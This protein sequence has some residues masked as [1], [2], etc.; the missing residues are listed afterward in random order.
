MAA[1]SNEIINHWYYSCA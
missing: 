1:S